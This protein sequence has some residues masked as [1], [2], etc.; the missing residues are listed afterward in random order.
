MFQ[1]FRQHMGSLIANIVGIKTS[2]FCL[3]ELVA[4]VSDDLKHEGKTYRNSVTLLFSSFN[5]SATARAPSLLKMF[6][7]RLV[8][9]FRWS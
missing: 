7:R 8:Y 2:L 5:A 6:S 1:R 3:I 9:L 4:V